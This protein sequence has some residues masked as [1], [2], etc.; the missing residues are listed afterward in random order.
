MARVYDRVSIDVSVRMR[1]AGSIFQR[2]ASCAHQDNAE[3][4]TTSERFTLL[5]QLSS[6]FFMCTRRIVADNPRRQ[7]LHRQKHRQMRAVRVIESP[8]ADYGLINSC[9][10][11]NLSSS[12]T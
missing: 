12:I 3:A 9:R 5:S 1:S 6:A 11:V 10:F 7:E 2:S 4:D 8:C